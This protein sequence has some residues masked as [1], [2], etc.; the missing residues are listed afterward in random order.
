MRHWKLN[1]MEVHQLQLPA[2]RRDLMNVWK[3]SWAKLNAS[4]SSI[5]A[6]WNSRSSTILFF[7]SLSWNSC[8]ISLML[9]IVRRNHCYN[10]GP[11][12]CR[13][14]SVISLPLEWSALGILGTRCKFGW[15]SQEVPVPCR[16]STNSGR[17]NFSSPY[18]VKSGNEPIS[19]FFVGGRIFSYRTWAV[20]SSFRCLFRPSVI[21]T[22]VSA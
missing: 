13:I 7:S 22:V 3:N 1:G 20:P 8:L 12:P 14:L 5:F 2:G 4:S 15:A 17:L 9:V 11:S 10:N 16:V 19:S 21:W 6:S 18:W